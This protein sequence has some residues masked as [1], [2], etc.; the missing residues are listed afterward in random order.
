MAHLT[1]MRNISIFHSHY[2]ILT[3]STDVLLQPL[4]FRLS[5]PEQREPDAKSNLKKIE[6]TGRDKNAS[7]YVYYKT[8]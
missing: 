1:V 3:Y 4:E 2:I 8:K 7:N 6:F 5:L